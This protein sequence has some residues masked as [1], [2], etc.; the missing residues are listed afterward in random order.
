MRPGQFYIYPVPLP[1]EQF[2]AIDIGYRQCVVEGRPV[3]ETKSR[4]VSRPEEGNERREGVPERA[5]GNPSTRLEGKGRRVEQF[6][7]DRVGHYRLVGNVEG[8]HGLGH[9][10]VQDDLGGL[11]CRRAGR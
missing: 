1:S 3:H 11:G 6:S 7:M 9:G 10:R 2:G 4:L 5:A 8:Y